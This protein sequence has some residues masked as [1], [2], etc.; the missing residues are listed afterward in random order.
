M[1]PEISK[2]KAII[3][4]QKALDAIPELRGIVECISMKFK[5][6]QENTKTT[7]GRVFSDEPERLEVFLGRIS[8]FPD[9]SFVLPIAKSQSAYMSRFGFSRGT[10]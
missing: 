5:E 1:P 9:I 4:L 2:S 6:W 7:M 10:P 8:F 3:Q